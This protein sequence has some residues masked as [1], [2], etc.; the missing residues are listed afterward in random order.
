MSSRD[1]QATKK[2]HEPKFMK[3]DGV[4]GVGIGEENGEQVIVVL[5]NQLS[6][7]AAKKIPDKLD[8]FK[9]VSRESGAI[10]AL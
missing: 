9:V 6:A 5:T 2:K 10:D 3:I 4:V 1:I 7:K 8:G